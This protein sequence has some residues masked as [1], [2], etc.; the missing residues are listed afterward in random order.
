[1]PRMH[2]SDLQDVEIELLIRAMQRCHGYDFS[3]YS[4]ASFKRRVQNLLPHFRLRNVSELTERV[5]HEDGFVNQ[6]IQRL[7]VPVSEMFRDPEVFAALRAEVLPVLASYPRLNIW[8]AGCARGEEVYSMA[9][10]LEEEGLYDRSQIYA[11][12]F[13]DAALETAQEGV[14]PAA[15]AKQ[16]AENYLKAGG[17]RSLHD[18]F[19]AR[20]E[21]IKLDEKL[22]RNITFANHNLVSDGV[23]S[24]VQLILCRNVLIY[25]ADPL[26]QRVFKLFRDSL[27]RNGYLCL[28]NRESIQFSGVADDFQAVSEHARI[29]RLRKPE[30]SRKSKKETA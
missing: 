13:N 28:G 30:G 8:Q 17:K 4:E 6:V 11:T 9:I 2:P 18:Y 29:Y 27:V 15:S 3:Q 14:Y 12:D 21:R 10:L 7:S 1:M 16:Y 26:K 5:I 24:E 25:F 20:Y 19:H 23:F 22:K